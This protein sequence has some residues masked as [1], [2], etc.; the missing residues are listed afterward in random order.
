MGSSILRISGCNQ[1]RGQE[2]LG[3]LCLQQLLFSFPF[4]WASIIVADNLANGTSFDQ[5]FLLFGETLV[6]DK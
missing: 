4:F 2:P 5:V 3:L 6:I 1:I